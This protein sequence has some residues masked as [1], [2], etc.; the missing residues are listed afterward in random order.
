[1]SQNQDQ[2]QNQNQNQPVT[3]NEFFENLESPIQTDKAFLMYKFEDAV[4]A[5]YKILYRFEQI[6]RMSEEEQRALTKET[7]MDGWQD[8]VASKIYQQ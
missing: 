4:A 2:N 8:Y 6:S 5:F 1:M 7:N 3:K